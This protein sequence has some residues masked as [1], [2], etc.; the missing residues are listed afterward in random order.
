[1]FGHSKAK[2]SSTDQGK[3]KESSQ[4]PVKSKKKKSKLHTDIT[5]QPPE[6]FSP[7]A[8][9]S[10]HP[11]IPC[12][13]ISPSDHKQHKPSKKSVLFES[14]KGAH[15]AEITPNTTNNSIES[16][17]TEH[18]VV[19]NAQIK[20][21]SIDKLATK[22]S[23][24]RDIEDVRND[25]EAITHTPDIQLSQEPK[26]KKRKK[27]KKKKNA[28]DVESS[29][30]ASQTTIIETVSNTFCT[31]NSSKA[32]FESHEDSIVNNTL[33]DVH[34]SFDL[35]RSQVVAETTS[36]D[37][38]A[39]TGSLNPEDSEISGATQNQEI[40]PETDSMLKEPEMMNNILV[41]N[42]MTR[43]TLEEETPSNLLNQLDEISRISR[44]SLKSTKVADSVSTMMASEDTRPQTPV[45]NNSALKSS[46]RYSKSFGNQFLCHEDQSAARNLNSENSLSTIQSPSKSEKKAVKLSPSFLMET[47]LSIEKVTEYISKDGCNASEFVNSEYV[48]STPLK[49]SISQLTSPVSTGSLMFDLTP[50]SPSVKSEDKRQI[51]E[52]KDNLNGVVSFPDPDIFRKAT[53][54]LDKLFARSISRAFISSTGTTHLYKPPIG[55]LN[56]MI[57]DRKL[58]HGKYHSF[59]EF[60]QDLRKIAEMVTV[61]YDDTDEIYFISQDFVDFFESV[62]K[63]IHHR[64]LEQRM[65]LE[66]QEVAPFDDQYLMEIVRN[67]ECN[68]DSAFYIVKFATPEEV[69]RSSSEL[70]EKETFAAV[71]CPFFESFGSTQDALKCPEK[72]ALP[73]VHRIF[74]SYNRTVL[75]L[76]RD[77]QNGYL[78]VFANVAT[79]KVAT[80][81]HIRLQADCFVTKP[82]GKR[83]DIEDVDIL[84]CLNSMKSWIKVAILK[85]FKFDAE[86]PNKF[87]SAHLN[88][89]FRP[90]KYDPHI[91]GDG[92]LA[93]I[94][95]EAENYWDPK[96]AEERLLE[97]MEGPTETVPNALTSQQTNANPSRIT[98]NMKS[99][100]ISKKDPGNSK[101]S[102]TK[103]KKSYNEDLYIAEDSDLDYSIP[104]SPTS[105]KATRH[106]L[107]SSIEAQ[108]EFIDIEESSE[109]QVSCSISDDSLSQLDTST[110]KIPESMPK[111]ERNDSGLV[112]ETQSNDDEV[113]NSTRLPTEEIQISN[114]S[115]LPSEANAI[116]LK[117]KKI[118]LQLG[119]D[120]QKLSEVLPQ[121]LSQNPVVGQFKKVHINTSDTS[122]VVQLYKDISEE[123]IES[124]LMELVCLLKLRGAKR[125]GEILSI[126]ESESGNPVGLTM[127]RYQKTLKEYLHARHKISPHQKYKLMRDMIAAVK[128]L[129]DQGIA[130]R[131]LSEVNVMVN[132]VDGVYLKDDTLRPK[133]ILIDYGKAR[134]TR[135][136]DIQKWYLKALLPEEEQL[137]PR[138]KTIP[139]HGY[140][141]YRSINT[142]PRTKKDWDVLPHSI[143]PLAE[144]IYSLG[145]LLWRTFTQ[146]N[147]WVGVFEDDIKGL[148]QIVGNEQRHR[149]EICKAIPGTKCRELLFGCLAVN[150][151]DRWDVNYLSEWIWNKENRTQLISEID[152]DFSGRHSTRRSI[153]R[154]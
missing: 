123:L 71:H 32:L 136:E 66:K 8:L 2:E 117:L 23:R 85:S 46:K 16:S 26:R 18:P 24:K 119:V 107:V 101:R 54:I 31:P 137:L 108:N 38:L 90:V 84:Q 75:E 80:K 68:K 92:Q 6:Q 83:H 153:G 140:K 13:R 42:S 116:Y 78:L 57:V 95:M 97:M 96:V 11:D 33:E 56:L 30:L 27:K 62:A 127:T 69:E 110:Q 129:H 60:M 98:S 58:W 112:C 50:Q 135:K 133:V 113:R 151:R 124:R 132:E 77:E 103:T 73:A 115:Q 93:H 25:S 17:D 141:R 15:V 134:L 7:L 63:E 99:T 105:S 138:I 9:N 59:E 28:E 19:E 20:Q 144:D 118:G 128:I 120:F 44:G 148:R 41:D 87:R 48:C 35:S 14:F 67:L 143:D 40:I 149:A 121:S 34:E 81:G 145:I 79:S 100:P 55:G 12:T 88:K 36:F 22:N 154:V 43:N 152:R 147:P 74:I 3:V 89:T 70:L 131:D 37:F 142:L 82:I 102:C 146:Q 21:Q 5:H 130:H 86:V 47:D 94:I 39:E 109:E 65:I 111:S 10:L 106:Y 29:I 51:L 125:V 49:E 114:A 150:D 104:E 91:L 139:D 64:S 1:P 76:A 52:T 45:I 122:T 72:A 53:Y 4:T 61:N 126:L